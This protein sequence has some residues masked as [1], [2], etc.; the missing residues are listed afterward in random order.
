VYS[1]QKKVQNGLIL[2]KFLVGV[3]PL[4]Q[5]KFGVQTL[6]RYLIGMTNRF[7]GHQISPPA[8]FTAEKSPEN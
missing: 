8:T 6:P 5:K 3:T 1:N 4:C 2:L 7:S